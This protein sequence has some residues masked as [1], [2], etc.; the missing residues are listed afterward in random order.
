MSNLDKYKKPN[1]SL[2]KG[3]SK[4]ANINTKKKREKIYKNITTIAFSDEQWKTLEDLETET[5]ATKSFIIRKNLERSGL[6]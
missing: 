2:L 3:G 4:E 5:G 1:H 6:F